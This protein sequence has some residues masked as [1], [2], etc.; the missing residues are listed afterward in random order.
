[1]SDETLED[2]LGLGDSTLPTNSEAVSGTVETVEEEVEGEA[3]VN[4]EEYRPFTTLRDLA[5]EM[6]ERDLHLCPK[7]KRVIVLMRQS[8]GEIRAEIE[9]NLARMQ[10]GQ[11]RLTPSLMND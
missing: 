9:R 4:A 10:T 11:G 1:M 2:D 6:P 8:E 7:L 5:R 3:P